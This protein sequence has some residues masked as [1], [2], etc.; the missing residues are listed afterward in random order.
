MAY[1]DPR[2]YVEHWIRTK[3]LSF[4][5][6]GHLLGHPK[7]KK[8][9]V[10]ASLI[11][12]DFDLWKGTLPKDGQ[13]TAINYETFKRAYSLVMADGVAKAR[14]DLVDVVKFQGN[15]D[16]SHLEAW[17]KATTNRVDRT[18]L[19]VM[20]HFIANVK[21]KMANL[22]VMW[23]IMPI[24]YGPQ[25][26]GKTIA[27]QQLFE[28]VLGTSFAN[29]TLSTALNDF[30]QHFLEHYFVVLFDEMA[31]MDREDVNALKR[32]ITSNGGA[33][34]KA[35]ASDMSEYENLCSFIGTTNEPTPLLLKDSTGARRF[36]EIKVEQKTDQ[37]ALGLHGHVTGTID[38]FKLWRGINELEANRYF[39]QARKEIEFAQE[40]LVA[41]DPVREFMK[42]HK[43]YP[44]LETS[45]G[46]NSERTYILHT[47]LFTAYLD[48][49]K[50]ANQITALSRNQFL[51]K[52]KYFGYTTVA[53]NVRENGKVG[54]HVA[55]EVNADHELPKGFFD[56]QERI[57]Q[58][59][60]TSAQ[61]LK[62]G[63]E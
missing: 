2:A 4:N 26:L 12:L 22:P 47:A 28:A 5:M 25:G 18:E 7:G 20:A 34:R 59:L 23:H 63:K 14:K 29:S 42:D 55:I 48:W 15:E 41:I 40:S 57:I 1:Y 52:L 33:F 11:A 49:A 39:L 62:G 37:M 19:A 31:G 38:Y 53:G 61:L 8:P 9:E 54:Y 17:L 43:C 32:I 35:H 13:P 6:Q 3:G 46:Q 21:R 16:L 45:N 44:V 50:S 27:I 10:I 51:R 36:F 60:R 24:F 56:D 30:S 58:K